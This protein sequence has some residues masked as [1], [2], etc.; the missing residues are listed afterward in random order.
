MNRA[1][2]LVGHGSKIE[3]SNDAMNRVVDELRR[4]EPSTFFKTAFLE[5]Q[6]PSIPD[7]IHL[8][9]QQGAEEIIVV[10]YFV[11]T[12]RHVVQDIPR[13][14]QEA[15]AAHPKILISLANYLNFDSRIVSVVED[16][17]KSARRD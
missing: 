4:R 17:I 5:L 2:L 13:I 6:S 12:G 15:Q 11:Q 1:V 9:L 7:G 16:R 3:G 14:V 8:C 10:P